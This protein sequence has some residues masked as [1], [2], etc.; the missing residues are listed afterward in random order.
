VDQPFRVGDFV[1]IDDFTGN[2]ERIGMRSTQVRT[3]DRTTVT[4]P[5]GKLSEL[6]I[7]GFGTRDRI[8]FATTVGLVYGTTEA[9]VRQV[10][11]EIERLLRSLPEIWPDAIVAKFSALGPS[12]LDIDVMCWFQTADYDQFRRIR[13]EVLLGILRI[14]EEA[15]TSIAFPTRTVHVE[16][17]RVVDTQHAERKTQD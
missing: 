10:V 15:G 16:H 1:K 9:Q 4:L 12:S 14:V 3:L 6:K 7:E 13:Q 5:N 11:L 8:R 17:G 2:V